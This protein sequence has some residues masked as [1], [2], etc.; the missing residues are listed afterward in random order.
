MSSQSDIAQTKRELPCF[1]PLTG[2]PPFL[3]LSFFLFS[4][5]TPRVPPPLALDRPP[6]TRHPFVHSFVLLSTVDA[7]PFAH[8]LSKNFLFLQRVAIVALVTATD[9]TPFLVLIVLPPAPPSHAPPAPPHPRPA[10]CV[11]PPASSA[12]HLIIR[13]PMC[14][15]TYIPARHETAC[16]LFPRF[17]FSLFFA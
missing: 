15:Y 1:Y 3:S 6:T 8:T 12:A 4:L 16:F 14:I 17:S 13:T 11:E 2:L 5:H 10:A 9:D 7:V